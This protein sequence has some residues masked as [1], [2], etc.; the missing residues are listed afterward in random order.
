MPILDNFGLGSY[1][2]NIIFAVFSSSPNTV[3]TV[4]YKVIPLS[5]QM[6]HR[7]WFCLCIMNET[8]W[9][10]TW[11]GGQCLCKQRQPSNVPHCMMNGLIQR[12]SPTI[13]QRINFTLNVLL[14]WC[15][16]FILILHPYFREYLHSLPV[17]QLMMKC[18]D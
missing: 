15:M 18:D 1:S 7:N 17:S 2:M 11:P 4:C 16:L 14:V 6:L 3:K 13:L 9:L 10:K 8:Y 5:L 12:Q